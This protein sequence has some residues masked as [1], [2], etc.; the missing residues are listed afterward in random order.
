MPDG[1]PAGVPCIHLNNDFSCKLF[2]DPSRP[3]VCNNFMP[4][5]LICGDNRY[6][7]LQNLQSLENDPYSMDP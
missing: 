5:N 4:E 1:K 6:E 2:N 7:A 3:Q